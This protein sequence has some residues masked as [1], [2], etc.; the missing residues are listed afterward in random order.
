M[1]C[2]TVA[3]TIFTISLV[4]AVFWQGH[5][6]VPFILSLFGLLAMSLPLRI[7]LLGRTNRGSP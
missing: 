4:L 6:L 3:L 5:S 1:I 7:S 2:N